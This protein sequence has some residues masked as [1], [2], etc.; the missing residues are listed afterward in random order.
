MTAEGQWPYIPAS[1]RSMLDGGGM[2]FCLFLPTASGGEWC[3]ASNADGQWMFP[4][5][6]EGE[7]G[8]GCKRDGPCLSY[9]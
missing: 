8:G 3:L 1:P 4:H 9:S 5:S 7:G 6:G 2:R